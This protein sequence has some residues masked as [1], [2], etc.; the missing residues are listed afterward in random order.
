[1]KVKFTELRKYAKNKG[2]NISNAPLKKLTLGEIANIC[3]HGSDMLK[4]DSEQIDSSWVMRH[5]DIKT[6]DVK[7]KLFHS[8]Q[9]VSM[10]I[11]FW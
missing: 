11:E 1:M 5:V 9:K 10:P 7:T 8:G 2:F 3:R 4:V 6:G